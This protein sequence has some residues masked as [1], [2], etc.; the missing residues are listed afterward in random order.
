MTQAILNPVKYRSL[1]P[2]L[3]AEARFIADLKEGKP[4]L[5]GNGKLPSKPIPH[6]DKDNPANVIRPEVIRFCAYGGDDDHFVL[7]SS[8]R[9][10]GAW[11]GEENSQLDLLH[12]NIPY[13]LAFLECHFTAVVGMLHAECAALYLNRSRLTQGLVA[14]GLKTQG[15]V[16]LRNVFAEGEVRLLGANIGSNLECAGGKFHN[17][18]GYALNTDKIKTKGSVFFNEGFSAE[19]EV[20]LVGANIGGQLACVNGKFHNPGKRALSADGMTVK[21]GV[22]WSRGFSAEGEVRLS[23]A[24]IDGQLVCVNGKF[25]NPGKRALSADGMIVKGGVFLNNGFSAEGEVRLSGANIGG[26]LTCE[27]GTINNPEK[28]A[29]FADGI[30][31]KGGVL[32]NRGFSAEGEVRL[33]SANISRQLIC[34]GGKFHNPKGCALSVDEV[35]IEGDVF[36]N[37]GFSA[38]GEVRLSDAN[39]NGQLICRNGRF[40]NPN[41]YALNAVGMTVKSSVS[42]CRNFSAEGEVRLLGANIG[43]ILDCAGGNFSN[44]DNYALNAERVKTG[45]HVYLNLHEP[46]EGKIPFI[47]NGRVR[48]A[49]ADIGGNFNCKGGQFRHSGKRSALAA[50]GLKSR[51]AVFLSNGFVARGDV[52]LHVAHIGNFVCKKCGP[53]R[54]IINLSST[55]AVAVDDDPKSWRLFKFLLDGFTYDT[56]F[57]EETSK[58][59]SRLG[60]LTS[61]PLKRDIKGEEVKV[62]F[63]PL[64]YEQTAKVL[65]GMGHTND[66]REI[67]LEQERQLSK[68]GQWKWWQK[69][70]RWGWNE[71][72]GY[73]YKPERTLAWALAVVGIGWG[74]FSNDNHLKDIVPHQPAILASP[75]YDKTPNRKGQPIKAVA[76]EF[77]EYPKFNPLAFS[78]DVFIPVFALHQEPFWYPITESAN[79]WVWLTENTPKHLGSVVIMT[80]LCWLMLVSLAEGFFVGTRK[81]W[82]GEMMTRRWCPYM[83]RGVVVWYFYEMGLASPKHW[84]WLEIGFGWIL[85][86]LFLLSITGLLRPRQSSG[87]KD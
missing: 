32:L 84:Y 27:G 38:E 78:A 24:N 53:S 71:F 74:V 75:I 54:G 34:G 46:K 62:P 82:V 4:C 70:L 48:F 40:H 42:L 35:T 13:A 64:P 3:P 59:K 25:H 7:G 65:F 72:A 17:P 58:D 6:G 66:A 80:F 51:G 29:L 79:V 8:I 85:T 86:S 77:W 21:G 68:H 30:T 50:G 12:A 26:Q 57:G 9:L 45:G 61:R 47:A 15:Y 20:L 49:N 23:D 73:G 43:R 52:D 37:N 18:N 14:S 2:L 87:G 31:V 1:L 56:F 10:W 44:P 28:N 63:S 11:I 55:K 5:V 60:W 36:F 33:S 22:F 81:A 67:L 19:G 83:L 76:N 41:K 69:F 16:N 39:I